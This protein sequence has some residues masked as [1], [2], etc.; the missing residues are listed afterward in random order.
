M[1]NLLAEGK[2]TVASGEVPSIPASSWNP[3]SGP[4][5]R[6]EADATRFANARCGI[7]TFGKV[8]FSKQSGSSQLVALEGVST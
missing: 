5:S 4:E 7:D 2:A 6:R 3:A 8:Q 1:L